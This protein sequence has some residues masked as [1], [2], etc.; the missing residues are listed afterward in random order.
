MSPDVEV[1]LWWVVG[2]LG[3]LLALILAAAIIFFVRKPM[4][5]FL[6]LIVKDEKVA[7]FGTTFLLILL[8]LRGFEAATDMINQ[9]HA[10][11]FFNNITNLLRGIAGDIQWVVYIGALLFIGYAIMGWKGK[12][13]EKE[14]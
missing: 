9:M 12:T 14:E 4:T 5:A 2:I 3:F 1:V 8:G 10:S 6:T 11:F 13:E 7:K